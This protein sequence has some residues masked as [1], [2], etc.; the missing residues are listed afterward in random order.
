MPT[1]LIAAFRATLEEVTQADLVLHVRDI[2]CLQSEE[3]KHD[4]EEVLKQLHPANGKMP[5]MVEVWNKMDL[6]TE[7]NQNFLRERAAKLSVP[8]ILISAE[9][10]EGTQN[11]LERVASIL[12]GDQ[13]TI[14]ITL[15][16][17]DS[18]ALN[19]LHQH[20]RIVRCDAAKNQDLECE[21]TLDVAAMGRFQA[22]FP[23]LMAGIAS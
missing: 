18:S 23:E 2:A 15:P 8:P 13:Q 19:W 17:K 3:Q 7:E 16:A 22:Q 1:E 14:I 21:V 6:L 20:G 12:H 5:R 11:L 4:V 9:T 10:G